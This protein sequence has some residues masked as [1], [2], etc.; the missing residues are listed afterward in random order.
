MA[1][2]PTY[3][4][5]YVQEVPSGVRTIAGVGTSTTFFL[6]AAAQGPIGRPVL[7][8]NY[9][10][11]KDN[12][13]E[14]ATLADMARYV[15]LFFLNGGTRA[16]VMRI[17][18]G[19]QTSTV[20][21]LAED[22]ATPVL[23]L[24]AKSPGLA[25]ESLRAAVTYKGPLPEVTFNLEIFRMDDAGNISAT[26]AWNGLTMDPASANYAPDF[27]TTNSDLVSAVFP[28]GGAP[29][30]QSGSSRAGRPVSHN[31]TAAAG[32]VDAFDTVWGA[33]LPST[34]GAGTGN[35]QISVDGSPF[36]DVDLGAVT[37]TDSAAVTTAFRSAI[38]SALGATS[39]ITV[40]V[41]LTDGPAP[42]SGTS[43]DR[44][45]ILT[46]RSNAGGNVLI[47][48]G[49]TNDLTAALMLGTAMGGIETGA[50]AHV[51]PAP[52][53]LSFVPS[54]AN[55]VGF[56]AL[57]QNALTSLDLDG[58]AIDVTAAMQTSA[59]PATARAWMSA[60]TAAAHGGSDGIRE[61][62]AG[63]RDAI[64]LEQAGSPRTFFYRAE[65]WG[66]RLAILPNRGLANTEPS[67]F[68]TTATDLSP[69]FGENVRFYSLGATGSGSF[70]TPGTTGD[71]GAPPEASD[72]TAAYAVAD[73][74]IDLFNLLV[75][76]PSHG[77]SYAHH[78]L[79]G[80]A[81]TFCQARRAFLLMDAPTDW[82]TA[83]DVIDGVDGLRVGLVSDHSA[84]YYPRLVVNESGLHR[85]VG[86]SGAMA[87]VYARI[88]G[89]RGVWK[90]PAGTEATI[91]GVIGVTHQMTDGQNG[92]INPEGVNAVRVFPNGIVSWGART[93]DGADAFG[94]EYKYVPIRRLAL[95][96]E[97]SLYRGLA[98]TVFEG[99]DEPLWAQIR[100]NVGA[101][102]HNLFR[103]G[104]FQGKTPQDAYFVKCDA[105]TTTQNDRNLGI[106]NVWVGFAPLKPAEFVV[107]YIQQMAGQLQA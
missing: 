65:V 56:G 73:E 59:T 27:L 34:A 101:F 103:Q 98:W 43:F 4:G 29:T 67:A 100:L 96:V 107:L 79:Y 104:A 51:R 89:S 9:T 6:G 33:I 77:V 24:S 10:D 17:A 3:P 69:F 22:G 28:G 61:K 72:Y 14:S 41:T 97:E 49:R 13:G 7:C 19:A 52:T 8:L 21:L 42:A 1:V 74:A 30:A 91:R 95:F 31:S 58:T 60:D 35:L 32:A 85:R 88:D 93:L 38:E 99:N 18:N 2:S 5:V 105:E 11:F 40:T 12:F 66:S 25:G 102:M 90:A 82:T 84:V 20:T 68:A 83:Q 16:Y 46:I 15:R 36:V 70:Q 78:S 64:N 48:P 87:G 39:G 92:V 76:P 80:E 57:L 75:L 44:T 53:G 45:R 26:E 55:L 54:P 62:L 50:F 71:D 81:S 86:A 63:L 37:P 47:R 106:V 23:D 94:S